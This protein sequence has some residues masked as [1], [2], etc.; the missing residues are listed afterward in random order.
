MRA[1]T[2]GDRGSLARRPTSRLPPPTHLARPAARGT[3]ATRFQGAA[4]R[5]RAR[6]CHAAPAHTPYP[7]P[8]ARVRPCAPPQRAG[9]AAAEARRGGRGGYGGRGCVSAWGQGGGSVNAGGRAGA[10]AGRRQAGAPSPP[11]S[12]RPPVP[13]LTTLAPRSALTSKKS[14]QAKVVSRQESTPTPQP[15]R[16]EQFSSRLKPKRMGG[17]GHRRPCRHGARRA[18][19]AGLQARCAARSRRAGITHSFSPRRRRESRRRGRAVLGC[20]RSSSRRAAPHSR[21]RRSAALRVHRSAVLNN[22]IGP[23][24]GIWQQLMA[25]RMAPEP[26]FCCK[27]KRLAPCSQLSPTT[28]RAVVGVGCSVLVATGGCDSCERCKLYAYIYA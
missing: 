6:A 5:A 7:S 19:G 28:T 13:P 10:G 9:R 15:W 3:R 26:G 8:L 22:S 20:S 11:A 2:R 21:V 25:A 14:R 27:D 1:Y 23:L 16:L 17:E 24:R 4:R 12:A 18:A